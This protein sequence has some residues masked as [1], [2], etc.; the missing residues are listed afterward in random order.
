MPSFTVGF[1]FWLLLSD[2]TVA[3]L[4]P[5]CYTSAAS[6][7]LLSFVGISRVASVICT[8][9]ILAVLTVCDRPFSES[10]QSCRQNA[11]LPAS[12]NLHAVYA[13]LKSRVHSPH[14]LMGCSQSTAKVGKDGAK[15]VITKIATLKGAFSEGCLLCGSSD[16]SMASD[17]LALFA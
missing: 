15:L 5:P 9:H 1:V 11:A 4:P 7:Q 12:A 10:D 2:Q 3:C 17:N 14:S 16:T 8:G 13:A 6:L